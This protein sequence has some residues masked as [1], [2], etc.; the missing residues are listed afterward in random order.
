MPDFDLAALAA[1][2]SWTTLSTA[3]A[4][5]FGSILVL[6]PFARH[7][8]WVDRPS[9]RKFHEGEIPL[10]GGWGV[11]LAL[12]SVQ[13]GGPAEAMAPTGYWVGAVLLFIVALVDDRYPIRA[14]YRFMVQFAA[15][16]AGISMGGQVLPDLGDL[17]GT[18]LVSAW[19]I[20]VPVSVLGTVAVINSVNFTD[21]ADGL[22]GGLGFISLFWFLVAVAIASGTVG[23]A[24]QA[25]AVYAQSLIPLAAAMMGGL[26]GFL[27]FNMRSPWRRKALVFLGDSGSMLVGFTLAWFAIHVT[28]AYGPHSVR[29][30]V[31][32]WIMAVPLADSASCIFRRIMAGVTPMTPDL[33]HL[34]HLVCKAGLTTGQS[35][36]VIH[37]ASFLCGLVGVCGWWFGIADRW[38]FAAFAVALSVFIGATNL[39]WR[40]IDGIATSHSAASESA[41]LHASRIQQP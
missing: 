31:C 33:K 22:C 36:V 5:A 26:A 16:I 1:T 21:G 32:L 35:V 38:M 18:G 11:L 17:L 24:S 20:V 10:I 2:L 27:A 7:T 8:G 39:A 14:R 25:P 13:L 9:N 29:P 4:V 37:V 41:E 30:V 3:A 6:R 34:H 23:E 28:S 40:R 15:A 12:L 19:W